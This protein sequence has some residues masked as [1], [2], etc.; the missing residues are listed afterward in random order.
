MFFG[1]AI[2]FIHKRAHIYQR[3]VTEL[4]KVVSEPSSS[5]PKKNGQIRKEGSSS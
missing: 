2:D 4:V 5:R 3:L 1:I